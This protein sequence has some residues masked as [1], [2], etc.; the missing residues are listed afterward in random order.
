MYTD[1]E[2]DIEADGKVDREVDGEA[3]GKVDREVCERP[4]LGTRLSERLALI[5]ASA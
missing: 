2:V 5:S 3:D 4:T 1:R